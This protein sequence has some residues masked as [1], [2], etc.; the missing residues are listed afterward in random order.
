[1][2]E[3]I[4]LKEIDE[5]VKYW[6]DMPDSQEKIAARVRYRELKER[7]KKLPSQQNLLDPYDPKSW[8]PGTQGEF[9]PLR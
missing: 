7:L 1:M 3:A 8:E 5:L 9:A 6:K 4:I 2:N